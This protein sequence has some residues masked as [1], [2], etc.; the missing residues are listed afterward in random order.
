[1]RRRGKPEEIAAAVVFLSSDESSHVIGVGLAVDG[2]LAQLS[3]RVVTVAGPRALPA[4]RPRFS[5]FTSDTKI[6]GR[7]RIGKIRILHFWISPHKAAS[8]YES[9]LD[10][11]IGDDALVNSPRKR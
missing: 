2:G 5:N 6:G 3:S 1:M 8:R 9:R 11:C 7:W 4:L 10:E